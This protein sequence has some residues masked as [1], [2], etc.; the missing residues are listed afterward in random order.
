MERGEKTGQ[1][2]VWVCRDQSGFGRCFVGKKSEKLTRKKFALKI[3]K[4][5]EPKN[6]RKKKN[7]PQPSHRVFV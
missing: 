5:G 3:D 1:V 6:L 2:Y 7:V 4:K